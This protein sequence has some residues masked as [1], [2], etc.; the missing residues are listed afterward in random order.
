M[1]IRFFRHFVS[2]KTLTI[3]KENYHIPKVKEKVNQCISNCFNSILTNRKSDKQDG[4][5]I[6]IPKDDTPLY[7]NHTYLLG[8]SETTNKNASLFLP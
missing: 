8:S 7:T 1:H 4:L 6:F 2:A 3:L 5:L